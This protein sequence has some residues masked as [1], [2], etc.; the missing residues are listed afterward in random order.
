MFKMG[1]I[2]VINVLTPNEVSDQGE[3]HLSYN[4][5]SSDY[6]CDT[7][8][9]VLRGTV[10]LILKRDHR[11]ALTAACDA[12]GLQGCFDYYLKH[13]AEAHPYSDHYLILKGDNT[14]ATTEDA[15]KFLGEQNISRLHEVTSLEPMAPPVEEQSDPSP[16]I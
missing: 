13:I 15:T 14:F 10:F 9:I 4:R 5:S 7:T 2:P 6:G 11:A 3:F 8:A 1:R 12:D 16:G